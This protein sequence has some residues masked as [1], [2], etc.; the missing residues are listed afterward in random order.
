[1]ILNM[2]ISKVYESLRIYLFILQGLSIK[3]MNDLILKYYMKNI[4]ALIKYLKII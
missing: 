2:E 1:M 3:L 4:W